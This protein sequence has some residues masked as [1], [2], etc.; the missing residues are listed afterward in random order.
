MLPRLLIFDMDGVLC[1]Y[2]VGVRV[3]ALARMAGRAPKAVHAAL[4]GSGFEDDADAGLYETAEQYLEA[5]RERLGY[6][7]TVEEWIAA[8]RAGMQ[9][10]KSVLT[11]VERLKSR[12]EIA[13]LTNNVPLLRET[14]PSVL[15]EAASLFGEN[16]FY[17]CD[18][19][20]R[21]PE[22]GAYLAVTRAFAIAPADAFFT[23][24]KAANAEGAAAAGLI[25]HHFTGAPTLQRALERLGFPSAG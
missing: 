23:D 5:F 21:K 15:P 11:L 13:I 2:D 4:W 16:L 8:R 3:E 22:P 1:R 25:A 9:P 19:K 18:L 12:A 10:D 14:L 17:S 6:R 20:A 24:D 7:L